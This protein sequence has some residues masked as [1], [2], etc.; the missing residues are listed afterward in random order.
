MQIAAWPAMQWPHGY[1]LTAAASTDFGGSSETSCR[2]ACHDRPVGP[3]LFSF[4]GPLAGTTPTRRDYRDG[5]VGR[6][7][8]GDFEPVVQPVLQHPAKLRLGRFRQRYSFFLRACRGLYR[9]RGIPELSESLA[10]DPLA[11][12]DDADLSAAVAQHGESLP[13]AAY[14]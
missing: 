10:T 2:D 7:D 8:H 9:D 5:I 11:A 1:D 12:L 13:H 3:A 4:R 6:R 14:R